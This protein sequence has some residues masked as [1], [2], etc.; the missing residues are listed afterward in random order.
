MCLQIRGY[1]PDLSRA[2]A[3]LILSSND[4]D[5]QGECASL[6][7]LQPAD[8]NGE[9]IVDSCIKEKIIGVIEMNDIKP[10]YVKEY[11]PHLFEDNSIQ[12]EESQDEEDEGED[13]LDL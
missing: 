13:I 12:K 10:K 2:I 7:G 1:A 3:G 4:K 8:I 9:G 6:L 5:F 11:A